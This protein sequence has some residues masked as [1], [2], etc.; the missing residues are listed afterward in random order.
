[1]GTRQLQLLT[2][3]IHQIQPHRYPV[4]DVFAVHFKGNIEV[5]GDLDSGIIHRGYLRVAGK[6]RSGKIR[7]RKGETEKRISGI[8]ER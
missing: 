2:Q 1:M 8:A 5:F 4:A 6:V 7:L 3:K